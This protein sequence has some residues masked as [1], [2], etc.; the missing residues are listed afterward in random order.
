MTIEKHAETEKQQRKAENS[1]IL[2]FPLAGREEAKDT[3]D[4]S[5]IKG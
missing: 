3:S 4:C 5:S 2:F 1:N